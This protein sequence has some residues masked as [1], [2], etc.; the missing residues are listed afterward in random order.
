MKQPAGHRGPTPRRM[1]RH[2]VLASGRRRTRLAGA[3][4]RWALLASLTVG[5]LLAGP[6]WSSPEERL[7]AALRFPTVS[8]QDEP[9]DVHAFRALHRYLEQTYPGVHEALERETVADLSLLYTWRGSDPSLPPMLLTAHLDVVPVPEAT[10][11]SWEQPPFA[12][13]I[14]DGHVWGRG[15]LD[16]KVGVLGALEAVESLVSGGFVPKR[17]LHLAFGHDE[18]IG[19]PDGAAGITRR[20]EERGV[21]LWFSLDEGMVVL[22]DG[23]FG[24][25]R[26]VA[27]IGIAEKGSV[28]I[29]M[30]ARAQGGH[31][32]MP[33]PSGAIGRISRAVLALEA[34]PMPVFREG[35][36][37]EMIAAIVPHLGFGQ[38][39][40]LTVPPFSTLARRRIARDPAVNAVLRTTTAVTMAGAGTKLNILPR[41]AW[42]IVNFRIVPGDSSGA[43]VER[44]RDIVDDPELEIEVIGASEPS[45][46]SDPRAAAYRL[47]ERTAT[48]VVGDAIVVPAL[49]VG[50][51]D[52]KHYG[53]IAENAYRFSPIRLRSTDRSRVHGVNERISV[54]SYR[55][56]IRFYELLLERAG[57][58]TEAGPP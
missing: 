13:V 35:V 10:L 40:M 41:E 47:I 51:T 56:A 8:H 15:A 42:A 54:A 23:L 14:A 31:S 4:G 7:A 57:S 30:T 24:L 34:N 18:E 46:T 11:S 43:V 9:H 25:E 48:D 27:L 21:R 44:V 12:G 5:P 33:P 6:A 26:P 16:D 49:V 55:E 32:S 29:R 39:L 37:E 3:V 58:A 1:V 22:D 52:S 17:T 38:R 28:S 36:F 53:R 45:P 50:G 20:L 2:A 19:G